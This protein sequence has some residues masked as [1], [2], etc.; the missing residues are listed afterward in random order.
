[1]NTDERGLKTRFLSAFIRVHQRPELF[2]S[3]LF[4]RLA[5]GAGVRLRDE[6][7]RSRYAEVASPAV[8]S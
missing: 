1:M 5:A 8:F 7:G 2:F 3:H 6:V 4:R